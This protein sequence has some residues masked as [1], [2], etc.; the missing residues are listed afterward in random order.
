M[1]NESTTP[2]SFLDTPLVATLKLDVEKGLY[3]LFTLAAIFTRF[4]RLGD[5]VMSH[6]ES[7][8]TY[9]SWLLY[10]GRGFQHTPLM[11]GPFLFHINA[12]VYSLFGA[13]DFTARISTAVFGVV[14]ILLPWTLR[15][16]LGRTGALV[17]SFL[18]LI[19]PMIMYHARYI[20]DE[21]YAV[22][23]VMLI[24]WAI[25]AY[26]RDR[27][28]KWLY[29]LVAASVLFFASMEVCF[30][31]TA[32]FG[33]FLTLLA[34]VEVI[35]LRSWGLDGLSRLI[36]T[37]VGVFGILIVATVL[38]SAYLVARGLGPT[39]PAAEGAPALA[40]PVLTNQDIM[41]NL[42]IMSVIGAV[43]GV[44]AYGLLR[45]LMPDSVRDVPA[46][47]LAIMLVVFYLPAASPLAIKLVGFDP[48]DYG[49]AGIVRSG[50]I[51]MPFL[52]VSIALGVWWNWRRFLIA[53]G[54][55][56]GIFVTL[57]T[58]VFTNGAGLATG[59]IG[60]LGYWLAQQ[61]VQRGSQP[62]YY[63]LLLVPLYEYLP[64]VVSGLAVIVY[65]VRGFRFPAPAPL[66]AAGD[67][68]ASRDQGRKPAP[69]PRAESER[70][71]LEREVA[72]FVLLLVYWLG[73]TWIVFSYAGE[74]MPWL[75]TYFALPMILVS[76]YF[77]GRIFDRLNWKAL[78]H[79]WVVALLAPLF[80]IAFASMIGALQAGAFQGNELAQ[81]TAS[82]QWF[83]SF[84][85]SLGALIALT[86]IVPKV[87]VGHSARI[88]GLEALALLAVL[89]I[90]TAWR[91]NY[92]NYDYPI[93][94]GV[95][96]HGGDGVKIAMSQIEDIS[97]RTAGEHSLKLAY[98]SDSEWPF[99]WYLR[100]YP[101]AALLPNTPSRDQL[102]VP[103]VILGSAS[104]ATV[105]PILGDKYDKFTYRLIWW[106]MEDYKG[107]NGK[108]LTLTEVMQTLSNPPMLQAIWN[109]WLSR[110]FK[111]Y[112]QL[113]S[114]K[115]TLDSWPLVHDFR[116]YVRK[117]ISSQMWDQH[118]GP[119][120]LAQLPV[121]PYLKG[122]RD[123]AA[124][125][126]IGE[127]GNAQGQ[128][129][130]PHGLAVAPDGSLYVA[131][132]NNHRIQKFDAS[133]KFVLEFGI[134]SGP[135]NPNPA[136]GTFNEPW[137]VAVGPDGSVYVAD[138]W[139]HR[140]QKFDSSGKFIT[141]WGTPGQTDIN[142]QGGIFWGPRGVAVDKNGRV[143]V[144]DTGNKRIEVFS[145]DGEFITQ[146][147]G[148]GVQPG[149]LDEP[150]GI[151]VDP[152]SGNL[153]VDDTWNQRI[154][155][156]TPEGQPVRQWQVTGWLDQSVTNKPYVAVDKDGNV[157]TTDPTGFRVLVFGPDGTFKATF[158]DVGTDEKS[159]Q[160]PVGI[161]VDDSGNVYVSDAGLSRILKFAPVK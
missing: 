136:S 55:W 115:H 111:L 116:L 141:M 139:N 142:G 120:P 67:A 119:V 57:F 84:V 50:G 18:L 143:Y 121:D 59:M 91:W 6:D 161:A 13:D 32:I 144:T 25:F 77:L 93:E 73:L 106:P 151:A 137:G 104:W 109:I 68:K 123:I 127:P 30:I 5:R 53:G 36:I 80:V 42:L 113:T 4:W 63:Y 60:S 14:L 48:V 20:R 69:E 146:F 81:L 87:G 54:I 154:Q 24:L 159:F 98:D 156:L 9:F 70:V 89:T 140:I 100:D 10:Q 94:Y 56:Y 12:L 128:F 125:Q 155:V 118:I 157:Y 47:D 71:G 130:A 35:R 126:V 66:Q 75:T 95:Y 110:D 17:T 145:S 46:F 11:H 124:V 37:V 40:P 85:V 16:W 92:I 83:S 8:H 135:N 108:S 22:V 39:S 131:D 29:L 15:R 23:W 31:F 49:T 72:L 148:V 74:K 133:G 147:G 52:A 117:D 65:I 61:A 45:A 82:G 150:V 152:T 149:Q 76:G 102:N 41:L 34:A 33:S 86:I 105:E 114:E 28:E 21:S 78:A 160:L 132:S 27:R 62:V 79:G 7:L 103:V 26:L 58:T 43:F 158:G 19:S 129:A 88:V 112:D 38:Q 96:A 51:F 134:F 90:R 107:K 44:A 99:S 153:V 64:L 138:T 3:L 122:K 1:T 97:R 101:N 2:L